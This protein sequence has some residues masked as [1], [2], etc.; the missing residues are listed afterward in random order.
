[1]KEINILKKKTLL[2]L[3]PRE[4]NP[5]IANHE[6]LLQSLGGRGCHKHHVPLYHRP[7]INIGHNMYKKINN[8]INFILDVYTYVYFV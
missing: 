1:M 3:L 2:R 8:V 6:I 7:W 4:L 5:K